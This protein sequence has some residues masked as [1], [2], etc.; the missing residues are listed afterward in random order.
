M[1]GEKGSAWANSLLA[2]LFNGTPIT[3]VALNATSSPLTNLYIALHT[4]DPTALGNQ[5]SNEVAY[6]GYARVSVART[7]GGWVVTG[8]SVSPAATVTFPLCTGL[9]T[10]ATFWSVG[11][12]VSGAGEIFYT[13]PISPVIAIANGITPTLL[14]S[15]AVV[16][17]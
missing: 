4:A 8:N 13:G 2:L 6:T 5:L 7:S 10:T 17:S 1:S 15:T 11:S 12:A 14:T 16:E 9:T 3:G